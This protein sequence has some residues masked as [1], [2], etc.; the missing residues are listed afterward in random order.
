MEQNNFYDN[1]N[2]PYQQTQMAEPPKKKISVPGIILLIIGL[3]MLV[4]GI[5]VLV[6]GNNIS[7][8]EAKEP[9]DIYQADE[10]D[11][12]VYT[13]VQYMTE[14]VAYYSDMESMQFYISLDED[15]NTV[16]VCIHDDDIGKYQP[17]ID[18]LYTE[19]EVGAPEETEIL[20]YAQPIEEDLKQF[21]LEGFAEIFGEGYIDYSNFEEY[22]GEYYIQVGQKN[23]AYQFSNWGILFLVL[24]GI[25]AIIGGAM[26]Y[27]KSN[28]QDEY[29]GSSIVVYNRSIVWGILGAFLGALVGGVIWAVV[30]ILGYVSGW[31]GVLI[32]F[33]AY[34]GYKL[35]SKRNDNFGFIISILL[36][37]VMIFAATYV[38]W[39]WSYYQMVNESVSGYTTF[40]RA[41]V[42]LPAFL[43]SVD[44]WGDFG[45]QLFQGYGFMLLASIYLIAGNVRK[46]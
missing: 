42:E 17:Y 30:N 22:F 31:I 15:W 35:L 8:L 9:V 43:D 5:G 10:I 38:A 1:F 26:L 16:L 7:A 24:G 28:Q 40:G 32:V 12:Y 18:W 13:P 2:G 20:G 19:S 37:V 25:L 46:R 45:A 27:Q 4:L 11:Q 21:V 3:V 29:A 41:L 34:T 23:D 44:G 39:G 36:G 6:L 14:S 33:F